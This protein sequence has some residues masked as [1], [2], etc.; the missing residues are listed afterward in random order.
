M[1]LL[2]SNDDTPP[3]GHKALAL[4]LIS[5][6]CR[7]LYTPIGRRFPSADRQVHCRVRTPT[8]IL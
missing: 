5:R 2:T 8:L 3:T 1:H 4:G 7:V 6:D